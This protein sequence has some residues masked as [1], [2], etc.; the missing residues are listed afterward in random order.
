MKYFD[1]LDRL[2]KEARENSGY[3]QGSKFAW[4]GNDIFDFTTYDDGISSLLAGRMI[5]VCRCILEGTTFKY[6]ELNDEHYLNF[7]IMVNMP[8]LQGKLN[9]GG[10]IRGAWF[11]EYGLPSDKKT[12]LITNDFEIPREEIKVF[13]KDLIDWSKI[14]DDAIPVEEQ[15]EPLKLN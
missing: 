15:K 7:L 13:I 6:Q 11:D 12:I 10:S 9:W 5:D 3:P 4:I 1:I 8:F 14:S 2:Y